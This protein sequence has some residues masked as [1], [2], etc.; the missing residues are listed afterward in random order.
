[1]SPKDSTKRVASSSHQGG[2]QSQGA[3]PRSRRSWILVQ[4]KCIGAHGALLLP[5]VVPN[6]DVK[7]LRGLVQEAF[8]RHFLRIQGCLGLGGDKTDCMQGD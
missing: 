3:C 4:W 8:R 5:R 2:I 1:M 7:G 6:N